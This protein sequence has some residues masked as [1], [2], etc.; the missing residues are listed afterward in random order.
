MLRLTEQEA[1]QHVQQ[2]L[3]VT[4][5]HPDLEV[6]RSTVADD[7]DGW[8]SLS[9]AVFGRIYVVSEHRRARGSV[10]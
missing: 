4:F 6:T 9:H 2:A 1:L 5:D 10:G 8:D 7:I 3:R